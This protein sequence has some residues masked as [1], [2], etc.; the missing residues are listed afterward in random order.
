MESWELVQR[1]IHFQNPDRLP[2]A[3]FGEELSD[4][5]GIGTNAIG[6][7]DRSCRL[8]EDE[9]HCVWERSEIE[10][11]GTVTGNP[12]AD[13]DNLATY[14]WPDPDA[15]AYYEGMEQRF[16]GME[17]K[18]VSTGIFM[19]LFERMHSLRGMQHVLTEL[20]ADRGRM[21]YLADRI[22]D[23]NLRV[24]A[25]IGRLFPGRIHG[26]SFTDDWGTELATLVSPKM[27][28]D[29]FQP[30][31]AK[32][33]SAVHAQGW[34]VR[35]HSCGKVNAIIEPLIEIGVDCLNL[36]Q[37]RLLGIEEIGKRYA[38]QVCFESC[39]DIQT[40]LPFKGLEA[41]R[42]EARLLM[43][44]WAT[45]AGGFILV[46]YSDDAAVGVEKWKKEAMFEAFLEFSPYK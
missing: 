44:N 5:R 28:C 17:G 8:T 21:E 6:T 26:F 3:G 1:A 15:P 23:F 12:L 45:P 32:I 7:G 25:N 40:T 29:F 30:R 33:F 31:Y 37:P 36:L 11:M 24:I 41:I 20:Y 46:D 34:D 2:V 22:V 35:M 39:C 19:L 43:E 38:G 18:Y 16:V 4:F 9:W 10:N 14:A 42:E 27:W 13:W